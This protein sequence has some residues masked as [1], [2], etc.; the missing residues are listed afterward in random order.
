MLK[1]QIMVGAF[2]AL[3]IGIVLAI[4]WNTIGFGWLI[5]GPP[6]GL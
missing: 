5:G 3:I 2:F 6:R 4:C 1:Y